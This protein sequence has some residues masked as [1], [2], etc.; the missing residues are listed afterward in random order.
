MSDFKHIN[1]FR[2]GSILQKISE[3]PTYLSFFLMFDTVDKDHSPLFAGPAEEYLEKFVDAHLGTTY[4]TTLRSFKKVLLKINTDMPWFWQKVGGLEKTQMFKGMKEPW[5]GADKPTIDIECLEENVEL[6]AI[7][8]ITLYK[9]A[10]YDYDRYV[11]ILPKNLRYF[12]VWIILS[13]VRTFQQD[14]GAR[15]LDIYGTPMPGDNGSK[16]VNIIP[17]A[18]GHE[19]SVYKNP[20]GF[21]ATLVKNYTADAKPFVKFELGYCEWVQDSIADMFAD[22][23]KNPERKKAKISFT[24]ATANMDKFKFGPNITTK[25][26]NLIPNSKPDDGLYP[27]QPFN[28]LANAQNAI[29]DK[30]NGIAGSF[31]NRFNNLKNSL[32]GFGNNPMGAVYPERLTGAAA[33]LANTGLDKL[34][35]LIIDNVHGAAGALSTASD[36][37]AALEAGSINGIRNLTGQLFKKKTTKPTNGTISPVTIYDEPAIDGSPDNNLNERVYDPIA[38]EQTTR[39]IT[40]GRIYDKGVDSSTDNNLNDNIYE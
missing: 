15:N 38:K 20:L 1:E 35:S 7:A 33:S 34:K 16:S 25:E 27:D 5:F 23:S 28:P 26:D 39:H 30:L 37:N 12:R 31:L 11:E 19:T 2:K 4:A 29:S 13:E 24:W 36:I 9:Q 40:P 14:L 17:R 10:V 21:D 3:D 22:A 32:P 6:T 18:K 8:L